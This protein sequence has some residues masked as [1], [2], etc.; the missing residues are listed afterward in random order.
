MSNN[1]LRLDNVFSFA[2]IAVLAVFLVLANV[3]A[4]R[5]DLSA[6][7]AVMQAG[8]APDTSVQLAATPLPDAGPAPQ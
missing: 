7:D 4:L 6:S 5:A 3:D 8:D 1:H 2:M